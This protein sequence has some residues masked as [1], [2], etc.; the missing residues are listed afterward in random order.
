[1]HR[2]QGM[3]CESVVVHCENA[4]IPGQIGV[5]LGR[6]IS[7]DNLQINL[8]KASLVSPHPQKVKKFYT[9]PSKRLCP[10][11]TCCKNEY[12]PLDLEAELFTLFDTDVENP[13]L[14]EDN[15][16]IILGDDVI[17]VVVVDDDDDGD[18]DDEQDHKMLSTDSSIINT[19]TV[20]VLNVSFIHQKPLPTPDYIDP[21]SV[22]KSTSD[23]Y[24][25]T[26][27]QDDIILITK[28]I[29]Q[30]SE[31]FEIWLSS[32]FLTLNKRKQ[33]KPKIMKFCSDV[34][35]YMIKESYFESC[36]DMISKYMSIANKAVQFL[37]TSLCFKLQKLIIKNKQ[38][39]LT[40][41][42]LQEKHL[43]TEKYEEEKGSVR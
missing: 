18:S 38:K 24:F 13:D 7:S 15:N 26:P 19:D 36:A 12:I 6:A 17:V 3:S 4:I 16:S 21:I 10:D 11:H 27:L 23:D 20:E 8:F 43:P 41:T 28:N 14:W 34:N 35:S 37:C 30:N 1:M 32:Q 33:L 25:D 42:P 9:E 40:T 29:I 2:A 5:A 39:L 22:L 31:P